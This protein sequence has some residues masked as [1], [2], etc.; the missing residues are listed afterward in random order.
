MRDGTVCAHGQ[1]ETRSYPWRHGE[2]ATL[3]GPESS[4]LLEPLQK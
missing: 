1:T 2:A 4:G 3:P